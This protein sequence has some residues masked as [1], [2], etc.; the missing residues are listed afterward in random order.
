M[1]APSDPKL[2][3]YTSASFDCDAFLWVLLPFAFA[4]ALAALSVMPLF[5]KFIILI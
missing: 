1:T 3:T 2:E 5:L 4:M